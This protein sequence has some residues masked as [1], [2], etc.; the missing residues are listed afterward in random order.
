M[1]KVTHY[2]VITQFYSIGLL[3]YVLV[4]TLTNCF[5]FT[6]LKIL[7]T[8]SGSPPLWFSFFSYFLAILTCLFFHVNFINKFSNSIIEPVGFFN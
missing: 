1:A 3:I 2:K 8:G 7:L 4:L 5:N 6:G